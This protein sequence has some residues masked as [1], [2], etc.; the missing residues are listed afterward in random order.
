MYL[1]PSRKTSGRKVSKM[2]KARCALARDWSF[3]IT[4]DISSFLQCFLS[5]LQTSGEKGPLHCRS[6]EQKQLQLWKEP[7]AS[8]RPL[9]SCLACG[10]KLCKGRGDY[11]KDLGASGNALKPEGSRGRNL[12]LDQDQECMLVPELCCEQSSRTRKVR[13]CSAGR[14]LL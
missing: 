3:H 1:L 5:S 9:S 2:V 11:R 8:L 6:E 4:G 10:T 12:T 7:A 13:P 14:V